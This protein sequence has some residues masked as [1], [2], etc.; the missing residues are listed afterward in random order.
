MENVLHVNYEIYSYFFFLNN[1]ILLID[2]V[3]LEISS[4]F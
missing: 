3:R 1:N 2:K 4:T